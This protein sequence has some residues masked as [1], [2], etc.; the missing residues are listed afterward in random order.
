[1]AFA[2]ARFGVGAGSIYLDEV[3][4]SGSEN[5]LTDCSRSSAVNCYHTS[6][7]RYRYTRGGAGVKCEG[8]YEMILF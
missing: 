8:N 5:N 6:S 4:C 3:G 7:L 1:M 2:D